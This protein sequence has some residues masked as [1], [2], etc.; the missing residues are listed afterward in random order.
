[1]KRLDQLKNDFFG[2]MR[3]CGP[4]VALRWMFHVLTHFKAVA[5]TGSLQSAD[6]AMG[7]GPFRVRLKHCKS[8]FKVKGP[9]VV[10]GIREM[11]VRDVYLRDGWL[12]IKPHDT[13]VDIGAN[14][15]NFTNMALSAEP[16]TR[17]V[18]I[19]PS[20]QLNSLFRQSVGLNEG[21]LERAT[22]IRAFI[23]KETPLSQGLLGRE[24]Y[25]DAE[26]IT[27][28]QFLERAGIEQID[29]LKCDIE[30]SEFGLLR[31]DSK[32]LSITKALACEVH[33]NGGD[34]NQFIEDIESCGFNIGPVERSA[35][36]L[37]M[38][39]KRPA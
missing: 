27:E 3:V 23:G 13:V 20:R 5:R 33:A 32:I 39:A 8:S 30:G 34:M 9:Q 36:V 7:A 29:V 18:A 12:K 4:V 35:G 24:E 19:E 15:G 1:M 25:G 14:I 28:D 21:Y 11:Y 2:L 38:L 6:L 10:N 37:I 31:K 22:L 26:W 17:V 16:T